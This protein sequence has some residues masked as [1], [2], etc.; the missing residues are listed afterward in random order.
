LDLEKFTQAKT[1]KVLNAFSVRESFYSNDILQL[2]HLKRLRLTSDV[3][4]LAVPRYQTQKKTGNPEL[5]DFLCFQYKSEERI[6][7]DII[8]HFQ[9]SRQYPN[10]ILKDLISQVYFKAVLDMAVLTVKDLERL[11]SYKVQREKHDFIKTKKFKKKLFTIFENEL[12]VHNIK[13][14]DKIVLTN[15]IVDLDSTTNS[16]FADQ[17]KYKF[18]I[19]VP[20]TAK[21]IAQGGKYTQHVL[22]CDS[23]ELRKEWIFFL[24]VIEKYEGRFSVRSSMS[25]LD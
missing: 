14:K 6:L 3:Q 8:Y 1:E 5:Q 21:R 4:L 12:E 15:C 24:Q 2:K 7:S 17:N 10:S 11:Q 22:G 19:L 13:Q 16:A 23:D 25:Y 9:D 20:T 18:K